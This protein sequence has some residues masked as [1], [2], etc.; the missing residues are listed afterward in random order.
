MVTLGPG[1]A[2]HHSLQMKTGS[3]LTFANEDAHHLVAGS[4]VRR[5]GPAQHS[6]R[7]GGVGG[8]GGR[9]GGVSGPGL[10][11]LPQ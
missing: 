10:A 7:A 1:A 9:I 11:S 2:V 8:Q 4:W 3:L 6:R 5:A